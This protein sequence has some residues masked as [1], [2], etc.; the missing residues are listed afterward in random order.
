MSIS[1]HTEAER[2]T[3]LFVAHDS[4]MFGAQRML[5]TILQTL[6]RQLYRPVVVAPRPGAFVDAARETGAE[7]HFVPWL[8]WV[9]EAGAVNAVGRARMALRLVRGLPRT[10]SALRGI[11]NL[12]RPKLIYSNTVVCVEGA[13]AARIEGIPHIWHIHEPIDGNPEL[14]AVLPAALYEL[15]IRLLSSRVVFPSRSVMS[16]YP[17]LMMDGNVVYNGIR[18]QRK[19]DRAQVRSGVRAALGI[20]LEK[21]LVATVG[22]LQPRK[23]HETFLRCAATI[24]EQREDVAF[25][26]V[27][28][29]VASRLPTL[30]ALAVQL[31]VADRVSFVGWWERSVAELLT[32][33]DVLL[34]T[35][36]QES[37]GLTVVEAFD[38]GVPVVSTRCGGPSELIDDRVNG[39]LAPVG[40]S[41][42]LAQAVLRLL[43]EP[44]LA[45]ALTRSGHER[46]ERQFTVEAYAQGIDRIIRSTLGRVAV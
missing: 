25:L 45:A 41:N 8:R 7:V 13:V 15:A 46:F 5:L 9:P 23:D 34:V 3:L 43:G 19:L 12:V 10:V 24:V 40:N 4:G 28:A 2:A 32:A 20:P 27:G 33:V 21:R 17:R 11:I 42:E 26:V 38:A 29:D 44:D 31:G 35:S 14:G 16:T 30:R 18:A 36:I 39:L 22:A 37:F 1:E 6:N